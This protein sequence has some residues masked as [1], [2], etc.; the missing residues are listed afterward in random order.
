LWISWNQS[1]PVERLGYLVGACLLASG[2]LHLL[3]LLAGGLSWEGPLSL[4]KPATFGLSFGLTLI[5]IVWV[6]SFV[7]LRPRA[8][9]RLLGWFI[10]ACVFETALVTLQAWR[11]VP[12]HFNLETTFDSAVARLLAAGGAALV[13]IIVALTVAAFRPN[14]AFPMSLRIAIRVGLLV[15]CGSMAVGGVMIASGMVL[16]L[17]G[18]PQTAYATAGALKPTHAVTMHGVLVLPLLARLLSFSRFSERRQLA[19]VVVASAGYVLL[20]VVVAVANVLG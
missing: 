13:A 5:T 15:L 6:A 14:P 16:V 12:S 11:G 8:R 9:T 3:L 17:S 18:D 1:R 4:R 2:A 7:P 10:V 19:V 20:A